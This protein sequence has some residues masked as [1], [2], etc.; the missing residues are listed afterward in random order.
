MT[1]LRLLYLDETA[2]EE[3][4][5]SFKA[6]SCLVI[7]SLNDCK[8][9]STFPTVICDLPSLKVLDVSGCSRL[10]GTSNLSCEQYLEQVFLRGTGIKFSK[11]FA[12]Q[13]YGSNN[14][15]PIRGIEMMSDDSIGAFYIDYHGRLYCARNLGEESDYFLQTKSRM[16]CGSSLGPGLPEWYDIRSTDSCVTIKIQEDSMMIIASAHEHEKSSSRSFDGTQTDYSQFVEF[17][18]QFETDEGLLKPPLV[19][20]APKDHSLGPQRF[21]VYI[22]A[23]WFLDRSNNL[24][25]W[26]YIKASVQTHCPDVEIKECGARLHYS[27]IGRE[28]YNSGEAYYFTCKYVADYVL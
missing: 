25:G 12:I 24:E 6:L 22:P 18:Y 10:E 21:G 23:K 26:N 15:R 3:L 14:T 11:N 9:L 13:E 7:L 28:L 17:V 2:I 20:R 1:S 16:L 8:K 19:L 27:N 4:P 5:Q